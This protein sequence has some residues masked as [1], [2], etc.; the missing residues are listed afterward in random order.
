MPQF[1]INPKYFPVVKSEA[2]CRQELY[3]T[4]CANY[5]PTAYIEY[6]EVMSFRYMRTWSKVW[7]RMAIKVD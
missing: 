1:E 2:S 3:C 4:L 7:I 5:L 6:A